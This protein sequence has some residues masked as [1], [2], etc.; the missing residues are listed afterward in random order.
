MNNPAGTMASADFSTA[1]TSLTASTVPH[2][3]ITYT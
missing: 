1:S 3:A 2:P